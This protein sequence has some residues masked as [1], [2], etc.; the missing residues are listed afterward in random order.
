MNIL[1]RQIAKYVNP[2]KQ[3]IAEYS[4]PLRRQI[5]RLAEADIKN[6]ASLLKWTNVIIWACSLVAEVGT[7]A[8]NKKLP[9][10]EKSFIIKQEL[11][12][13]GISLG[14]MLFL[15]HYFEKIG[16]GLVSHGLVLPSDVPE[17]LRHKTAIQ[18]ILN[19]DPTFLNNELNGDTQLIKKLVGFQ[20]GAS[21][22]AGTIGT[23]LAFNIAA[24]LISNKIASYFQN[25]ALAQKQQN[26]GKRYN[27]P[28]NRLAVTPI[29]PTFP[30][31]S[32]PISPYNRYNPY[33]YA[34][35]LY[36]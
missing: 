13:G 24:P 2:L 9:P 15:A 19:S 35:P 18:K 28:D 27:V 8:A 4:K 29:K 31:V 12:A 23:I 3:Q 34:T 22:I 14:F 16:A 32:Y 11:A 17:K 26:V 33:S 5:A 20:K 25:R 30:P 1:K 10:K 6:H 36:R 21:V 7:F